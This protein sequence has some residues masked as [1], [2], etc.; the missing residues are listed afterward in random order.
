MERGE[1]EEKIERGESVENVEK[2][3]S[4]GKI[5][6]GEK[7][8]FLRHA[9][10][11]SLS[12]FIAKLIGA[13]YRVP[14]AN[15]V[16]GYGIGLYQMV[17]PVYSLLL[18]LSATGIP[19]AIS[20]LVSE[21]R[22]LGVSERSVFLSALKLF[23]LIGGVGTLMM[24]I[25]APVLSAAQG[26]G[27]ILS[28]YLALAPS[29]FLV[30][31]IAVFRG[32]FQGGQQMFPTAFSEIAEQLIKVLFGLL[33]AYLYRGNTV[34]AVTFLL[35]AVTVSEAGSLVFMLLFYRHSARLANRHAN[36]HAAHRSALPLT[37]PQTPKPFQEGKHKVKDLLSLTVPVTLSTAILPLCGL[38]ESVLIVRLLRTYV[39]NAV[40][41]YGLFSGGAVT[42][43]NL[44]VS[45]AH[46]LASASVVSVSA[47]YAR[48]DR[49]TARR[50]IFFALF[51]TA[52]FGL[53]SMLGLLV[54]ARPAARLLF[55]ALPDNEIKILVRLIRIYS[56]SA[57]FLP[58]AQ[59]LSAC[60]TGLGKPKKA[61]WS[62]SIA[63]A[64]RLV[65]D[66]LLVGVQKF[67][68]YGLA[69]AADVCYLV[70]FLGNLVYNL[71]I[72]SM[73]RRANDYGSRIRYKQGR[74]DGG[75]KGGRFVGR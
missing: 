24:A 22:A 66:V 68:V 6:N 33:F 26:T 29:V 57:L 32:Y 14:L 55:A 40:S 4:G 31:L 63:V 37:A 64:L 36:R 13:A 17:Y 50:K 3:E 42:V 9:A 74:I 27:E 25:L 44:P 21:R 67:S 69:I 30:S 41:L 47:A 45:V 48:G 18:T 10:V 35:F 38:V 62:M 71:I 12:G 34:K 61:A 2:M 58:C 51:W 8:E 15:L 56:V 1:K 65:L 75:G 59:T 53:C 39:P 49:P 54:L 70:A 7:R 11:L 20:K 43:V 28:G 60:L 19:T 5:E 16:G 23:A 73:R 52:L 72:T 46:G